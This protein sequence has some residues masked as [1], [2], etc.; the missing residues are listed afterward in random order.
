MR[1]PPQLPMSP[2]RGPELNTWQK[3]QILAYQDL[4]SKPIQIA[5]ALQPHDST[6]RSFLQRVKKHSSHENIKRSG[7]PRKSSTHDRLIVRKS[8]LEPIQ[9]YTMTL[10]TRSQY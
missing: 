6:V 10:V 4:G 5:H 7:R 9:F 3:A 1:H 8:Q 2:R